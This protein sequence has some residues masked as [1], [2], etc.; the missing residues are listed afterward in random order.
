MSNTAK[1]THEKH[2]NFLSIVSHLSHTD[3]V[4]TVMS[5]KRLVWDP[6]NEYDRIVG[7]T[8]LL[9]MDLR[10]SF[11][12]SSRPRPIP[13]ISTS[14]SSVSSGETGSSSGNKEPWLAATAFLSTSSSSSSSS[15]T[16]RG[17]NLVRVAFQWLRVSSKYF[18]D[19]SVCLSF[20]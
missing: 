19:S 7:C 20:S 10:S 1:Q 16:S 8:N 13:R 2:A 6:I 18:L 4:S 12:F 15:S 11:F 17:G 3:K 5:P 14:S 9:N